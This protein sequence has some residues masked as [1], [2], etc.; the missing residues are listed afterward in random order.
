MAARLNSAVLCIG[1]L[2]AP[3][4]GAATGVSATTQEPPAAAGAAPAAPRGRVVRIGFV[5]DGPWERN[6]EILERMRS[7]IRDLVAGTF[8]VRFPPEALQVADWTAAGVAAALDLLMA[9]RDVDIVVALGV[10][11]SDHACRGP[12]PAKPIIA[13]AVVDAEV[14]GLPSRAGTSGVRNLTYLTVPFAVERDLRTF[15][16]LV[17]FQRCAI[18][19]NAYIAT[20]LPELE[21]RFRAAATGLGVDPSFV[22]VGASAAQAL[23]HL[24]ADVEAAYLLPLLQLS[25]ASFDSLLA[26]LV[27]RRLPTFSALGEPEVR[28]GVLAT[29]SPDIFPQMA[30]RLAVTI[31]RI[32]AGEDAG[33]IPTGVVVGEHLMI[34]ARTARDIGWYPSWAGLSEAEVIDE[35]EPRGATLTLIGAMR[36]ALQEN[37]DLAAA[38]RDTRAGSAEVGQARSALLPQADA[39]ARGLEIDSDRAAA[40]FGALPERSVVG[41]L[42][43]SQILFSEGAFARWS[44][45]RSQQRARERDLDQTRLDTAREAGHAFLNV[46]R[47]R[48]LERIRKENLQLTRSHLETARALQAVGTRGPSDVY[49]WE[50]EIA[51][52]RKDAIDA[53]ASRNLAEIELNRILHRPAEE[54]FV[55]T[56]TG[57]QD[58]EVAPSLAGVLDY[59]ADKISFRVLRDFLVQEGLA[60]SPELQ[61]FDAAN[62]AA[63][64][65][66]ES[67]TRAFYL[68]NVSLQGSLNRWWAKEGAGS[69]S[70]GGSPGLPQQDDT[71]WSVELEASYPLLRGG[72]RFS[73]RAL[74]R[75]ELASLELQRQSAVERIEQR[76]RSAVHRAG[77][78]YAGM[79]E[80][81]L[82]ADWAKRNLDLTADAYARGASP[83]INL[84]D[85]QNAHVVAEQSAADAVYDFLDDWLEVQ[86]AIGRFDYTRSDAERDAFR[87]RLRA[88]ATAAGVRVREH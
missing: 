30:R 45:A 23:A 53:S 64:R 58:P 71:Y 44:I 57:L 34:N 80:A 78:S 24:P 26:G 4:A 32:L 11:V 49:R 52:N 2:L 70:G 74:A 10:L 9:A 85:A 47:T 33:T 84:L 3:V 60:A 17:G 61:A 38:V 83:F 51:T 67:A 15:H 81:Q 8:D 66:L 86:R 12:A 22:S 40:S 29:Q 76:I 46:Q 37:V 87:A 59:F 48:T 75:E 41:S 21:G 73:D 42:E 19:G 54:P 65:Q 14:R 43:A 50:S 18:L 39:G 5:V 25:S 28:R 36:T 1:L 69:E 82:A 27:S 55:A 88:A 13:P 62:A 63:R 68:P 56:E 72:G 16:D 77:A 20:S 7:E 35:V 6:D 31:Q 79:H